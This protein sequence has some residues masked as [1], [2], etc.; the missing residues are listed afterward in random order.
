MEKK[1]SKRG[2]E[3]YT[4]SPTFIYTKS[5]RE[6]KGREI[7]RERNQI[8]I[9]KIGGVTFFLMMS[10]GEKEKDH[11]R[12]IRTLKIGGASPRGYTLFH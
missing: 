8:R 3:V 9:M 12:N 6:F 7:I 2:N 11:K 4:R 10:K 1:P 5:C